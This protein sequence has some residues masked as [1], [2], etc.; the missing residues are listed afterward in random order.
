MTVLAFLHS[1]RSDPLRFSTGPLHPF[2]EFGR[3]FPSNELPP[4]Q[5]EGGHESDE[6]V[7]RKP[8]G[9]TPEGESRKERGWKA[10]GTRTAHIGECAGASQ[11]GLRRVLPS[12]ASQPRRGE[13]NSMASIA[14]P[15]A[16]TTPV[17]P[18]GIPPRDSR[19]RRSSRAP[20]PAHVRTAACLDGSPAGGL[21][22][23]P[24]RRFRLRL[25]TSA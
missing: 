1:L 17:A 11:S 25:S 13:W 4:F 24:S 12:T 8:E 21:Q 14:G 22:S 9:R 18:I 15:G 5:L 6:A 2:S 23:A 19:R 3:V 10:T 16:V 7:T 20:M